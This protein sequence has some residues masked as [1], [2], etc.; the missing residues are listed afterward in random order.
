M[1]FEEFVEARLQVLLRYAVM[2]TGDPHTAQDL[3]QETMIRAQLKWRRVA[4]SQAPERYVKRMLTNAYVDLHRGSWLKR[5]VLRGFTSSLDRAV[6]DH[7]DASV[8]RD[9]MW[10]WLATLPP[11]QRAALV[12]R[13]YEGLNDT[14]IA[15]VL[16]CA[17]GTV[18]SSISRALATLRIQIVPAE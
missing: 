6:A 2:L 13:Y 7:V 14:E 4:A 1:T 17:V 10:A 5:V 3:V 9:Q 8:E 11:R 12:L 18:R 15:D 16:H